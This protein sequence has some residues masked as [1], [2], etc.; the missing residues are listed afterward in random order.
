[1]DQISL[2]T[3]KEGGVPAQYGPFGEIGKHPFEISGNN[4]LG[5]FGSSGN[6]IDRIGVH[7]IT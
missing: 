5:F 3:L 6:M 4:I 7:Y 2:T 1:M